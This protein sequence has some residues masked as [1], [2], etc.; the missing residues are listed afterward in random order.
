MANSRNSRPKFE[1]LPVTSVITGTW[2]RVCLRPVATA[3]NESAL[4]AAERAHICTH[5][6]VRRAIERA[7]KRNV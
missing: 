6:R 2:C 7:D 4:A 5:E 1:R 3:S